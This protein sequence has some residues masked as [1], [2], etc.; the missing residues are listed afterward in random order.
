MTKFICQQVNGTTTIPYKHHTV[1]IGST[2]HRITMRDAI[3]TA[4]SIDYMDYTTANALRSI[5]LERY[6]HKFKPTETWGKMVEHL[7]GEFVEPNLIHPTFIM[8]YPRDISPF[9]KRVDYDDFHVERWEVYMGGMEL[10]NAFTELNDP[11]DQQQRFEDMAQLYKKDDEDATP[12]D[13]DYLRSMRYGMPP[14]GGFGMGID[15]LTILL[16][17]QDS[18]RDVL[19]FPHMRD[20]K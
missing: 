2:W 3:R 13:E 15:R 17:N 5:I 4:T 20:E 7:F 18:I 14:M 19:L 1:E 6:N 8:D 12:L 10:G 11:I 9:A 16:T